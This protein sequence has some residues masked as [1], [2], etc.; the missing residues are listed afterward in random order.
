M[1]SKSLNPASWLAIEEPSAGAG[2]VRIAKAVPNLAVTATAALVVAS[3]AIAIAAATTRGPWIDEFWTVWGTER[4]LP[5]PVALRERWL[6]DVHPPLFVALSRLASGW[7]G[8]EITGR[9]LQNLV[10]MAGLLGFFLFA[11]GTWERARG[12]L[13]VCAVLTFTSY[14]ATGYFAEYRSYYAQFAC[15]IVFFV[16][17]YALLRGDL[18]AKPV[19]VWGIFAAATLLLMNL[20]FV[21]AFLTG[22]SLCGIAA[23]AWRFGRPRLALG[24]MATG[25][26][27]ALPMVVIL[28]L[29]APYLLGRAGH[30]FWIDTG[31]LHAVSIIAGSI[32]K[33]VGVNIVAVV[34]AYIALSRR[35]NQPRTADP[36]RAIG[37]TFL[38]IAAA[39][40]GVLVL[41]NTRTPIIVDRY[42]LLCSSA[43][44]VGLSAVTAR[45]FMVSRPSLL[46]LLLNA[47][48]F[49][50]FSAGK[51][52]E[53]PRWNGSAELIA[54]HL[55][56]CPSSPVLAF[57]FPFTGALADEPA[58]FE[59]G[60]RYLAARHGFAV[61]MAN[62]ET[63][64]AAGTCPTI[65][66]TEHVDWTRTTSDRAKDFVLDAARQQLGPLD[67]AGATVERTKTGAIILLPGRTGRSATG[68]AL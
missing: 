44:I 29:Q 20:H 53:E 41:I 56:R 45:I 67:L 23:T 15:G 59:T 33:G 6:T 10:P 63:L 21:T 46:C 28:M 2:G 3:I 50:G 34:M 4:S 11:A 32:T 1:V 66:W 9:R 37:V 43:C 48:L 36:D 52:I 57:P 68:G 27:S 7:L 39:S 51:L 31:P 40:I 26:L 30:G 8:D 22:L 64:S 25:A 47:A 16:C 54:A 5:W 62:A 24:M 58:V 60:Y 19:T 14:F 42:L 49:L 17:A 55:A 61:R 18:E 65:L 12:F 38:A 13:L 35:H